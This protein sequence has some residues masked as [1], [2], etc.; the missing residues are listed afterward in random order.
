MDTFIAAKKQHDC[1]T[2]V[3]SQLGKPREQHRE[4]SK[5]LCPFHA[6]K[7]TPSF[8]VWPDHYHCYGC[9]AHGDIID[10]VKTRR[11]MG[12]LEAVNF[13]TNE[14]PTMTADVQAEVARARAMAEDER[15]LAQEHLARARWW[16]QYAA[17]L[18]KHT[19]AL[20]YLEGRGIPEA[21]AYYYRLGYRDSPWGPA[22]SIPWTVKS[23]PRGIQYRIM[24]GGQGL[25]YRWDERAHGR[26]TI[27]NADAVSLGTKPLWMVEGAF[28]ALVLIT[29]GLE[30]VALVNK[31][32]WKSG[33]AG[34]FRRRPVFVCLDP[35]A[36]E[37]AKEIA[38]DIGPSSKVVDLP[39]KPD[40]LIVEYGWTAE[41]MQRFARVGSLQ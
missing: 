22:I 41:A 15:Q 33:W 1:R 7:R 2:W 40:D 6:D 29:H 12:T 31:T 39:R 23:E 14:Q 27:Y 37:Q 25:R 24:Q 4:Y 30:S 11:G 28:K 26:P 38:R 20:V 3:A 17:D 13:L 16:E 36:T 19:E 9:G 8:T 10:W 21:V 18:E 5:W 34:H 35:D 32:G